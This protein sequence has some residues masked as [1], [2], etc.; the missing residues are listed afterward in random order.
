MPSVVVE[1]FS[2]KMTLKTEHS[3]EH[4][5][6]LVQYIQGKIGEIDPG[7]NFPDL[8]LAILTLLNLADDLARERAAH[9]ALR[10]AVLT[11]TEFLLEKLRE[12]GYVLSP[13]SDLQGGG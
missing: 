3:E 10:E 1:L 9:T 7:G 2:R 13:R 6:S 12:N 5:R 8:Q 4:M 11:R